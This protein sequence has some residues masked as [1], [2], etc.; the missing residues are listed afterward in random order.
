MANITQYKQLI[1]PLSVELYDVEIFNSNAD[2][3]DTELHKLDLK[4]EDQD[5]NLSN[6]QKDLNTHKSNNENPHNVTK[7]QVGLGNVENK[8]SEQIR[9][10]LT[11][12]NIYNALGY[13]PYTNTEIDNKFSGLENHM[14]INGKTVYLDEKDGKYGFN[15]DPERGADTFIPFRN[16]DNENYQL[17]NYF[18]KFSSYIAGYYYVKS[19]CGIVN[20]LNKVIL[21]NFTISSMKSETNN[22]PNAYLEISL[23]DKDNKMICKITNHLISTNKLD[24]TDYSETIINPNSLY[25]GYTGEVYIE[26]N[27]NVSDVSYVYYFYTSEFNI[28]FI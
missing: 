15:T 11:E 10:D 21:H 19:F 27:L 12:E 5:K 2:I 25:N 23:R 8:S 24:E 14:Q 4:N 26:Y 13:V 20:N 1:K 6:V 9:D 3:I 17:S 22:P 28:E 7:N 16:N 18:G